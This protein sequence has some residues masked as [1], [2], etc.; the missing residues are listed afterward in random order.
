[1]SET[2]EWRLKNL[3]LNRFNDF[4]IKNVNKNSHL[5]QLETKRDSQ[6]M[7]LCKNKKKRNQK[8]KLKP[9]LC[10]DYYRSEDVLAFRWATITEFVFVALIYYYEL[11]SVYDATRRSI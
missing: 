5:E 6:L 7:W 3:I 9:I 10:N 8:F 11:R 1:M 2:E 4:K